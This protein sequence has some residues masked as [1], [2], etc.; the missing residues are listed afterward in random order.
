MRDSHTPLS[1]VE[2]ALSFKTTFTRA[3]PAAVTDSVVF[4]TIGPRLYALDRHDGTV[5][6]K[7]TIGTWGGE[8]PILVDDVLYVGW[9]GGVRAI[10]ATSGTISWT[11]DGAP[12]YGPLGYHEGTVVANKNGERGTGEILGLNGGSEAW[13]YETEAGILSGVTVVDGVA[14]VGTKGQRVSSNEPP[15]APHVQAVFAVSASDGS[16]KW[17]FRGVSGR[18]SV[19][20]VTERRVYLSCSDDYV[21]ALDTETGEREWRTSVPL[22]SFSAP[23]VVDGRVYVGSTD[24]HV[25]VLDAD[26]GTIEYRVSV[27]A[28]VHRGLAVA[29]GPNPDA[30]SETE[31]QTLVYA[32][33]ASGTLTVIKTELQ[34][35]V[36][37][38]DLGAP[39]AGPPSVYGGT[40]HIG[41]DDGNARILN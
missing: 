24:G 17:V 5:R 36:S 10:D 30:E 27:G 2:R 14:Y 33:T 7:T 35:V 19:P 8:P 13:Q 29:A 40:I 1:S 4:H 28:S 32:G 39:P 25:Y 3:G 16:E 20:A 37:E 23:T 41:D 6:W 21:Y 31:R 18:V 26:S 11:Y 15:D 38:I 34:E 22:T 9:S 12:S